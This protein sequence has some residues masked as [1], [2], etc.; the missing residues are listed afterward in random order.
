MAVVAALL[1]VYV[2]LSLAYWL[3]AASGVFRLKRSAPLLSSLDVPAPEAWPKLSVVIPAC[4]E[5]DKLATAFQTLLDEDYP[6]LE[7]VLVDDRSTDATGRIVD[8]FV[9]QDSR[10][11]ALRVTELPDGWLGKVNALNRG[12]QRSTGDF[13]LFTDADVHFA[14]ATLRKAMSYCLDESLDHL[15]VFPDIWPTSTILDAAIAVFVRHFIVGSRAWNAHNPRSSAYLGIGAFNLVRR[16]A[17][18]ATKGFEWLR[19]EVADDMGLGLMMK[20]SG[21]KSGVVSAFGSVGLHWYRSW[22]EM[23]DGVEKAFATLSHF[24]LLRTLAIAAVILCIELSPLLSLL[25]LAFGPL[26]VIGYGGIAVLAA[27]AFTGVMLKRWAGVRGLPILLSPVAA[28][29]LVATF[30]R[31][32]LKGRARGGVVWRE[33]HYSANVLRSG[34]RVRFPAV[35]M[36]FPES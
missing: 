34:M 23:R 14:P 6:N 1:V 21:A 10:V 28:P 16:S 36:R 4:N 31:A 32:G 35:L 2:L 22:K 30:V 20:Q 33:T 11:K 12:L 17:F 18:E 8:R 13:V 15:T 5:A 27:F 3:W 25:P 26:R 19:L 9:A 24:S 29:L 7:L